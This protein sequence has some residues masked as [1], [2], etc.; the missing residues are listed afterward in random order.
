MKPAQLLVIIIL[1][2]V[3][4]SSLAE[5]YRWK[6]DNGK[7]VFGDSPPPNKTTTTININD[8]KDSGTQFAK[9]DQVSDFTRN[10]EK[11]STQSKSN[12]R[13]N[14]DSHCRNYISQLN[15]VNI[16][17]EHTVTK[18]DQQKAIDLRK[19]IKRE[20]GNKILTQKFDDSRCT[21]YRV[22]LSKLEVY[23]THTITKRDQQR[24]SDLRQQITRECQ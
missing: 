6:D 3:T 24:A 11:H 16:Y 8:I 2:A 22:D 18:R 5:V 23:L 21:A 10:A 1:C 17:L 14:I 7:I 12:T 15:K 13:S 19:L 9:P 20:C 4:S